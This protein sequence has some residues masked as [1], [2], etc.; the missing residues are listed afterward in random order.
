M[1]FC[2]FGTVKDF[3]QLFLEIVAKSLKDA[4]DEED[5]DADAKA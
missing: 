2:P 4:A 3:R 5:Q 1:N